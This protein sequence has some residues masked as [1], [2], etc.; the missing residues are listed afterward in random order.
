[1]KI[2][3][4]LELVVPRPVLVAQGDGAQEAKIGVQ[5][6]DILYAVSLLAQ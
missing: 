3:H 5:N 6:L 2:K 1:M 4:P